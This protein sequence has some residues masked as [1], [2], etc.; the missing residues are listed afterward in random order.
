MKHM[1]MNHKKIDLNHKDLSTNLTYEQ[2]FRQDRGG[3]MI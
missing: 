3:I 1:C 2:D